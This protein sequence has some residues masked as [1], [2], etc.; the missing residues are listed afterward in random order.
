MEISRGHTVSSKRVCISLRDDAAVLRDFAWTAYRLGKIDEAQNAMQK[1]VET[2]PNAPQAKDAREFLAMSALESKPQDAVAAEA[3]INK[4]LAADPDYLPALIA[5]AVAQ[6]QRD[7]TGAAIE[8]LK[9]ILRDSPDFALAQKHLAALYVR[10]PDKNASASELATKARKVLTEDPE[11]SEIL[12]EI[13]YRKKEY[14]RTIQ[15]LQESAR[16]KPLDAKALFF[17]G[18]SQ[19]QTNLEPEG[20]E[21]LERAFAATLEEPMATEAR[22]ALKELQKRSR[23]IQP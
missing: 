4:V 15:L 18:M 5:R 7:Q 22:Q 11:L 2:N 13:S 17:L 20:R 14:A 12:A 10:D 23:S 19:L 16:R 1:L 3:E 6:A 9:Q 21:T 8:T